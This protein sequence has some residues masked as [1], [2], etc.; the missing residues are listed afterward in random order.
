MGTATKATKSRS[1]EES[2]SDNSNEQGEREGGIRN[3]NN[4]AHTPFYQVL[5]FVKQMS[6][7]AHCCS[8]E[9]TKEDP[10]SS[11]TQRTPEL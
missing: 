9:C 3:N 1:G 7:I 5:S 8:W 10:A 11:E 6:T 4:A 2:K